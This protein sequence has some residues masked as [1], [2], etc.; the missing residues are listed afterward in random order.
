L[1]VGDRVIGVLAVESTRRAAFG[2][3]DERLLTIVAR[4]L[5]LALDNAQLFADVQA[6]I[7]EL[8]QTQA[9]LIQTEKVAAIGR[10]TASI[11][12][13]VNN[14][15]QSIHNCLRLASENRLSPERQHEYLVM[16]GTEVTRLMEI[17][18]RMLEF[19]RPAAAERAAVPVNA[20]IEDVLALTGKQV[21]DARVELRRDLAAGLPMVSVV[22]N[23]LRQVFLNLI[24]N[25]VEAMPAGGTLKIA[26]ASHDGDLRIRFEDSGG[27]IPASDL[28]KIFEPF[29]TT[30]DGGT[31]LGLSVTYGIVA[32][33]G[34]W[35][36][37]ESEAGRG[38]AFTV[39]LPVSGE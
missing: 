16:A 14:P 25:A 37:V 28:S 30:K 18:R 4:Q 23:H 19:Y 34:G 29:F 24:L 32:A 27:G 3:E 10:L 21:R 12:H 38:T 8:R 39:H 22:P 35:I 1:K 36:D 33:H 6:R 26:T 5:A 9:Q 15:L 2:G 20:L 31:G 17:V 13:E 11:A 7:A